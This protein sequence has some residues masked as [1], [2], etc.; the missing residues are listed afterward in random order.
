MTDL[1]QFFEQLRDLDLAVVA[2]TAT[3][4]A[5]GTLGPVGGLRAKVLAAAEAGAKL[6]ALRVGVVGADQP[7]V[8]AAL[9]CEDAAPLRIIRAR[10]LGQAVERLYEDHGPRA[11]LRR[12]VRESCAHLDLLGRPVPLERL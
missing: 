2:V 9:E 12:H 6:G 10:D 8:P 5:A 3:L 11:A 7:D 4:D 1:G